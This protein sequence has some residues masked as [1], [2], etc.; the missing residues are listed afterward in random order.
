MATETEPNNAV[1]QQNGKET[2]MNSESQQELSNSVPVENGV[3]ETNGDELKND[4][5]AKNEDLDDIPWSQRIREKQQNSSTS[6]SVKRP[7]TPEE[8]GGEE[9]QPVVKKSADKKRKTRQASPE[10]EEEYT[11]K[12]KSKSS[13]TK[14]ENPTPKSSAKKET[15]AEEDSDYED[16]KPAK[17]KKK[18]TENNHAKQETSSSASPTKK[19]KKAEEE[20]EVW[21]WWE[22]QSPEQSD[23]TIKWR[24]LE[25]KGPMF[26]PEYVPLP[27]NIKFKYN[28][29]PM[30]LSPSAEEVATFYA[31]MLDHDYTSKPIFNQNFFKD[32]RKTMTAAERSTI[33]D[34]KKCDFRKARS[35]EEK[36]AEKEIKDKEAAEYG[37]AMLDGY[38]QKIGNFRIEPPGLFRGRGEHP[39]M[40]CLKLRVQPED[41]IINCSKG[42][43]I[44][45][46]KGHKWKEVRHDNMVTW[47]CSWN[48][49]VLFSNKYIMLNPSSKLK[50]Q[51]DWEKFEKARKLKGC[52][53]PIRDQY[54]LDFKSKEMRIRQRAVALY[55]IDK[56]ALRAGN[57][58]DTDEAADTVGCC[59]LRCEHIKLH[60]ELDNQKYV[61]EFDFL[62]KDSIRYYN[63]VPVEK[64]VF[65]NLKIFMEGKE[66]GDDLFDRLDTSSL[67]AYLKELMDGLTAKVFRTYNASITLQDQLDKLTNPDDTIHAKLLS[68]NRANRQVAILC[69]HQRAVPKTH[70]KAMETLQNKINEK[71]KEYKEIKAELKKNKNDE[72]LQKKYTR[73]KEQLVKLKTQHTDKD[74]NKQIALGTSKLNYLDPRISV[75]WCKKYDIPIEKIYSKTQR[76]KFRWAIDMTKEDF[77]F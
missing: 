65:K 45:P 9:A 22:E 31:K 56:F 37:F 4:S 42:V 20:E 52:V 54:L 30:D 16:D 33:T 73:V 47:L 61:V 14:P 5:S 69:N 17:M 67:N 29:K 55:F 66:P 38:K 50:G 36:K 77:I 8:S 21:K 57:E 35:K 25:H 32:W 46:P 76:D 26:A 39:K 53:G 7:V 12:K 24:T 51:K 40:G 44:S 63:R 11:P 64:A 72:K 43:T 1:A 23:G 41:V 13:K 18:L 71:K 60:E 59:S 34:L 27:K 74:E 28:G 10:S 6:K 48:E 68:Y 70:D 15:K 19:K 49:N 75:A 2:A 58:K 62:G 3:G